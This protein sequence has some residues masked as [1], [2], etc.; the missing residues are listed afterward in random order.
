MRIYTQD[1]GMEFRI[2]KYAMLVMKSDKQHPTDGMELSHQE[3][4]T[5]KQVEMKKKN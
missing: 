1:G 3:K 4:I 2:E 5:I